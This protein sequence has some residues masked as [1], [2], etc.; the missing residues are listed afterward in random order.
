MK[1]IRLFFL[2]LFSCVSFLTGY[3]QQHVECVLPY[4]L[5]GGK[6][7]VEMEM[8]GQLRS[9]IFDTGGQTAL[10]EE[11]CKELNLQ[12]VDV[13][14]I[15]DVNG[16]EAEYRRVQISE[17]TDNESIFAFREVPAVV[18]PSPSPFT[19]FNADGLIGSDLLKYMIVEID[20]KTKTIKLIAT[21]KNVTP[22]LRKMFPF[23]QNGIMPVINLQIGA[24]NTVQALFDTGC[25]GFLNLKKTDYQMLKERGALR[26]VD[27][28]FGEGAVGLGEMPTIDTLYRVELPIVALGASRFCNVI[29]EISTPPYTLLGVKILDYGKVTIDYP[30]LRFYFEPYEEKEQD[31]KSLH[32]DIGL[33]VKDGDLVV[34]AV[35]S[36]M[37]GRVNIGDRVLKINGEVVRK[38]DFCESIINGIPELKKKKSNKLTFMTKEGEKILIYKKRGYGK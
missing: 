10:T 33:R 30:R 27:E 6:M 8:N 9:F 35:W 37:K 38:Y 12:E 1:Y 24:G 7:I 17:F 2:L 16:K 32:N 11:V 34:S 22:S 31:M 20:G 21:Q 23:V 36:E 25:P 26:V 13:K 15:V 14:K 29:T 18:I 4:R 28:G 5:V 19:C 3:A